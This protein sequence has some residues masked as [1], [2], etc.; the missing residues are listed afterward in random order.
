MLLFRH[1][2]IRPGQ[3]EMVQDVMKTL[4]E[5]LNLVAHAPCGI[6]KTDASLSPALTYALENNLAVFFL[7][8]KISQHQIAIDVA[9]GLSEK[10]N[11]EIPT[12]DIIGRK[13]A[14][15]HPSLQELDYDTFYT[16]CEQL[17]KEELCSY[18]MALN[19][20][21][22][23]REQKLRELAQL[24]R[25]PK[26]HS[27][28][29]KIGEEL[30]ICPYELMVKLAGS[31][32]LV[33]CDYYHIFSPKIRDLMLTKMRKCIEQ[34]IV[35]VDEA[36][37][38]PQR[39][40]DHLSCS[41]NTA[42]AQKAEK[43][44]EE[45]G[46]YAPPL[47]ERLKKWG[48][49][50]LGKEK[51]IEIEQD[52]L[53][54]ILDFGME[55]EETIEYLQALGTEYIETKGKRSALLRLA[56]FISLWFDETPAARILRKTAHGI[57]ISKKYLDV[58]LVTSILNEAHAS[59]VMS[60]TLIPPEMYKDILGL[61]ENT[62]VRTYPSPFPKENRLAMILRDATTRFTQ[63]NPLTYK[64]IAF[65][66]DQLY[67]GKTAVFFPSYDV[68]NNVL[69]LIQSS[70]KHVQQA[71]MG[72]KELKDVVRKFAT[73]GGLLLGVQGGSLS[74]GLDFSN[75]EITTLIVV[76]VALEEM[77][78]ETKALITYYEEKFGKGWEYAYFL[79]AMTKALQAAGRAIR[80]ENDRAVIVFLDERFAWQ[81]Y[82]RLF[83][84]DLQPEVLEVR[85]GLRAVQ[86]F[87]KGSQ[88]RLSHPHS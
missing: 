25:S 41:F 83:P 57:S 9:K 69:P 36:H 62:L 71:K 44:L 23:S 22:K 38:L 84:K 88:T 27:E 73:Y 55:R 19:P 49:E 76:G 50:R 33:I 81:N 85:E 80:K 26:H 82:R 13:Y 68:L 34:L 11:I 10:Y 2:R 15:I 3:K 53:E 28:T 74:E 12:I 66:I 60:A 65:I 86:A 67:D 24:F 52:E 42:L 78:L 48:Y 75:N 17:R 79:P 31:A 30:G 56:R 7:T 58:A 64:R 4:E 46:D 87:R 47:A 1:P 35:I 45:L 54:G 43:E 32:T 70:P 40:R 16:A 61:D 5:G 37:N 14:C 51:E 21:G 39:V 6:G 18:H 29:I 20:F 8:P 72:P 59:I 77:T 63:R